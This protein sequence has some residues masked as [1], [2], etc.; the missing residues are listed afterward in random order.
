[1]C[2]IQCVAMHVATRPAPDPAA[3]LYNYV[4]EQTHAKYNAAWVVL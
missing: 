3:T 2:F 4:L 1:M